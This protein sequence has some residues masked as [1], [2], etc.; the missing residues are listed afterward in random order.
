MKTTGNGYE[1]ESHEI[2][3]S[4]SESALLLGAFF[5]LVASLISFTTL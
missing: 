4:R 2:H 3:L 1:G 5:T